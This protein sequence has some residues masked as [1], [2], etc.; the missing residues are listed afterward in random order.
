MALIPKYGNVIGQQHITNTVASKG[1]SLLE[2]LR[3]AA[4]GSNGLR[5]QAR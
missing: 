5:V 2:R 1:D 4:K 3:T